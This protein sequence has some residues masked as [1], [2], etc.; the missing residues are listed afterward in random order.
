MRKVYKMLTYHEIAR[1]YLKID[2][3][4]RRSGALR[5]LHKKMSVELNPILLRRIL[6]WTIHHQNQWF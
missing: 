6:P 5:T 3:L 2:R 1:N 4:V